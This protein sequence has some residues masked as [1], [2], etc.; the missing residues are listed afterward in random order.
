MAISRIL[1][2]MPHYSSAI[3]LQVDSASNQLGFGYNDHVGVTF[4]GL[5]SDEEFLSNIRLKFDRVEGEAYQCRHYKGPYI[6]MHC[7]Q[8]HLRHGHVLGPS[9]Y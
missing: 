7:G 8:K 5:L 3:Q 9:I 6:Y 1:M 4:K 2:Y